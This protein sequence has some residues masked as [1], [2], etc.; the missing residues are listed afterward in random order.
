MICCR[1]ITLI[2]LQ[3]FIFQKCVCILRVLL[4]N[5]YDMWPNVSA[6]IYSAEHKASISTQNV[7]F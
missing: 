4:N 1:S 2:L 5:K 3:L 7:I 6:L